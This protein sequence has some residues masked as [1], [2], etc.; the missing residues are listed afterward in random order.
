MQ[1]QDQIKTVTLRNLPPE[2]ARFIRRQ[3]KKDKTSI[4]KTVIKLL[5]QRV[6][7]QGNRAHRTLHHD[8]DSLAGS[9]SA[10]EA[11]EFESHLS[12]ERN[13]DSELWN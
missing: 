9:W 3:A 5:E 12:A 13:I 7:E 4:N 6:G 8:L 10:E 11:A 2:M 1:E